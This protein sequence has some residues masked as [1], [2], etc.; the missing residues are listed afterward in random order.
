MENRIGFRG[1]IE[2]RRVDTTFFSIKPE[3]RGQM[4]SLFRSYIQA[5]TEGDLELAETIRDEALRLTGVK[6]TTEL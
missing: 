6:Q 3:L 4:G 1:D 5:R 2:E